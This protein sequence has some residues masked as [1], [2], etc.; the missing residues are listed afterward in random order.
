[1]LTDEVT[2]LKVSVLSRHELSGWLS[3][4]E[5]QSGLGL[6]E[7]IA[8][9]WTI[10]PNSAD[11]EYLVSGP[12]GLHLVAL[13]NPGAFGYLPSMDPSHPFAWVLML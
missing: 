12:C 8:G 6:M 9:F 5:M 4:S 2:R 13:M 3:T 11:H 7:F 10:P 1:M